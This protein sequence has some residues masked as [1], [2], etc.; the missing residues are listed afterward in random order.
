MEQNL[1]DWYIRNQPV[2][3]RLSSK[4]ESLLSEVF[5]TSELSYHQ[6]SSRTKTIDSVREKGS[7]GKY[8]DPINQI[9]DFSGIRI[10]TYVEDEIDSICKVIEANF[11]IDVQNSSNKS[12]DLGV[13][14]V[15]YKSVHY[16]AKLKKDRL[17]LPEYKQFENR[18]FE[19]Q[20]RTILQHAWAEIEHDR[21]YKF[22]GKLP[23]D[24]SRRFKILAGVLE[25]SDREFNKISQEIDVISENAKKATTSG[26]LA[27][28][29]TSVSISEYFKSKFNHL[30]QEGYTLS[31]DHDAIGIDELEKF[32]ITILKDLDDILTEDVFE[33]YSLMSGPGRK[34]ITEVGIIRIAMLLNNYEKYFKQSF[35]NSF[36]AFTYS[37]GNE[38]QL[39]VLFNKYEVDWNDIDKNYGVNF[40]PA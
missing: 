23:T 28:P 1:V 38:E 12:D 10:I 40:Y 21:N 27:I 17:K 6:I 29:I 25:M 5:E 16:I 14:R 31:L 2:Y 37:E 35:S 11:S 7:N 8:D 20:V 9:Q 32:G 33:V 18:Y 3:K 13:D 4:V 15:G 30:I 19:I 22:S 39:N 26:D 36:S 24:I 34:V